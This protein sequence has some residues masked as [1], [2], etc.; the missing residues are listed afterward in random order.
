MKLSV[1]S[2]VVMRIPGLEINAKLQLFTANTCF[3]GTPRFFRAEATFLNQF[4][5]PP[6]VRLDPEKS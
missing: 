5:I 3:T 4:N 1:L 6:G 2:S